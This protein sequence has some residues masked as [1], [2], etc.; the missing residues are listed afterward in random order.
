MREIKI[1]VTVQLAHR[2]PRCTAPQIPTQA[3]DLLKSQ[4]IP[5]TI[6]KTSGLSP[7]RSSTRKPSY[8]LSARTRTVKSESVRKETRSFPD[9][10]S[11][12]LK[13]ASQLR[14]SAAAA[15]TLRSFQRAAMCS[16]AGRISTASWASHRTALST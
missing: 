11:D 16:S 7:S 8:G 1:R 15:I 3:L 4:L 9:Q 10:S 13:T 5:M 12:S 14:A 6:L 2:V